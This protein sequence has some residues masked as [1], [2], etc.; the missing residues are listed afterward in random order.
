DLVRPEHATVTGLARVVP[1][2]LPWLQV[3]HIDLDPATVEWLS[4][5]DELVRTPEL[6]LA[7]LSPATA[8]RAGRRWI[9]EYQ[10]VALSGGTDAGLREAGVYLITGGLGGIGITVAEHLAERVRARVILL[11]RT[12][13]PPRVEWDDYLGRHGTA[14]RLGRAIA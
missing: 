5:T 4:A 6:D 1:L 9:Q 3:H 8:I 14:D 13:L 7:G 10:N 12:E 11:S 2:E